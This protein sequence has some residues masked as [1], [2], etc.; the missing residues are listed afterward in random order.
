MTLD[1]V[2]VVDDDRLSAELLSALL[3][4]QGCTAECAFNG[5]Q[6]W[7]K[8][9]SAPVEL[10]FMDLRMPRMGGMELLRKIKADSPRTA[11]I[12]MTA[13]ATVETAVECMRLGAYDFVTK[14][15]RSEQVSMLIERLRERGKLYA[16][17]D[18]LR[19]ELNQQHPA[20]RLITLDAHMLRVCEAARLAA[21]SKA[22]ILLQG[23]SGTGKELVARHIHQLSPRSHKPFICVNCGALPEGLLESELFGHERGAFTGA[24]A[25]RIGRF[26]LAD[27]G[28]LLLDEISEI[29]PALQV[30]L[31]RVLEEEEFERVG[32]ANTLSVDVRVIATTNRDLHAAVAEGT[33]RNDLFYRLNVVPIHLPPLRERNVDIKHLLDHFLSQFAG[34]NGRAIPR[35]TPEALRLLT[36]YSWPGN[37]R[38]V[39]NLIQRLLILCPSD[40]IEVADLP[41][42]IR[43]N[44]TAASCDTIRVGQSLGNA[45]EWLILKTLQHTNGNRT[46]AAQMLGITART[47]RNKLSRYRL[48]GQVVNADGSITRPEIISAPSPESSSAPGNGAIPSASGTPFASTIMP[49]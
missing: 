42:E 14:P 39:K 43:V 10:V 33:F 30:K 45:E 17:N 36:R 25:R 1:R 3:Q 31:L 13:Y 28:T 46:Q 19:D 37:V 49:A 44:E 2:L 15:F 29:S 5:Q 21:Q 38:E 20:G 48:Q 34:Q 6:G 16:Q 41:I 32:G 18:Y 9:R 40:E 27:G 47:L 4:K 12:M 11:I 7:K 24:V 35:V 23:E 8:F 26:E 22:S